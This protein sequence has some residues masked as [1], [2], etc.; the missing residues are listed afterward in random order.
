V[1]HKQSAQE[2]REG[3]SLPRNAETLEA[4]DANNGFKEQKKKKRNNSDEDARM[5]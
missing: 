3:L 5:S 2:A 4:E 1:S